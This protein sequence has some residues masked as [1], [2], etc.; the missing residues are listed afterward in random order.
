MSKFSLNQKISLVV[1]ILSCGILFVA[2]VGLFKSVIGLVLVW[3]ANKL[4][5]KFGEEGIY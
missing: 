3:M 5:K 1:A 4:A 2:A